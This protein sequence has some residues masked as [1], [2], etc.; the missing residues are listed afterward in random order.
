MVLKV[1]DWNLRLQG[2]KSLHQH[3]LKVE[4]PESLMVEKK[5]LILYGIPLLIGISSQRVETQGKRKI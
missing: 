5:I 3:L 4:E 2:I 1:T